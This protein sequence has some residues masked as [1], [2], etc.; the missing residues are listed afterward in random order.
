VLKYG[1]PPNNSMQRAALRAAAYA[2]LWAGRH[3]QA[4]NALPSSLPPHPRFTIAS[5][6][7]GTYGGVHPFETGQSL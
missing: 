3:V 6:Q 1:A 7:T 5:T 4:V 2:G